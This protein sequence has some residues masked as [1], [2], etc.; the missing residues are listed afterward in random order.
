M[1]ELRLLD[2]S[3]IPL[4]ESW[5]NKEHVKKWY[6]VPELGITVADWILEIRDR[7]EEFQWITYF[8]VLWEGCPIGLCL[9][10]K[11][12][13]SKDE[14]FGT[15]P[16]EGS[17]GIDYFIGEESQFG[18]GLGKKMISLLVDK[19]FS[20]PN[21]QRVTADV[22]KDNKVSKKVLLACGFTLL[23]AVGN[24]YVIIRN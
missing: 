16:L 10:Y 21:A 14:N 2:D 12:E 6:E 24:R 15:L 8:I 13:D 3:D 19:I 7:K 20:F 17:Y 1:I 9:C 5:L 11:C 23:D 18:K 4:V 22:D